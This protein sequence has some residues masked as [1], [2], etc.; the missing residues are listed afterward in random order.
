MALQVNLC[1]WQVS[2]VKTSEYTL[3]GNN[4]YLNPKQLQPEKLG[5][6]SSRVQCLVQIPPLP[7]IVLIEFNFV[8]AIE[9][10]KVVW[11]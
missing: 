5:V 1:Y 9:I 3:N 2:S 4:Y 8:D 7:P 6:F 10:H 11:W